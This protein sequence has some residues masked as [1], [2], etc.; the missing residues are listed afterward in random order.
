MFTTIVD[1]P[2]FLE[3]TKQHP[4]QCSKMQSAHHYTQGKFELTTKERLELTTK[5]TFASLL[6]PH[7][8][9]NFTLIL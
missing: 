3:F 2:E 7:I 9:E 8:H 5:N 1:P 4:F 6:P